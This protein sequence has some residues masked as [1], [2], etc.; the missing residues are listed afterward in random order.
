MLPFVHDGQHLETIRR[1]FSK[2]RMRARQLQALL[3]SEHNALSIDG[4]RDADVFYDR[5]EVSDRTLRP[6]E[7]Q[8]H[9]ARRSRALTRAVAVS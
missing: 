1:Q 3:D 7:R 9:E 4:R 6:T 8:H 2:L 5:L